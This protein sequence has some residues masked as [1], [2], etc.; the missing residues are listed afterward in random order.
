MNDKNKIFA[1][2]LSTINGV[3]QKTIE[4][5]LDYFD[6]E[7]EIFNAEADKFYNI[8][9]IRPDILKKII[10]SKN[11][12]SIQSRWKKLNDSNIGFTYINADDY[13]TCERGRHKESVRGNVGCQR[14]NIWRSRVRN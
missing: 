11:Y 12:N 10:N 5:L 6:S 1:Y 13:R 2:W 8:K 7:M 9:G 14:K 4:K 3:G